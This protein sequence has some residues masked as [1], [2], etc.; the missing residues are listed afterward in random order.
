[1][2]E[3][4]EQSAESAEPQLERSTYEIIRNRLQSHA[5]ELRSRL[6]RLNDERREV[7]GSIETKLV[8]TARI[9]T[10]HNC[11]PR[12]MVPIGD[13][14][15]FGFNVLIGLRSEINLN[16]V[17][18][19]QK[20]EN[21][22]FHPEDLTLLNQD[23]LR[24]DFKE[25]YKYYKT[26]TFAKFHVIAPHVYM[27]FKVGKS[28]RDVKALK[29]LMD[30]DQ[31][32][33]LDNRNDHE[34][35]FPPKHGF[36]WT[37]TRRDLHRSGQHPHISV[38]DRVFVETIGG[39]LTVKV[40]DNTEAGTGIYSEPVDDPDQTLDDAEIFYA[41]V[42]N[43]ILLKIRPFKEE[44]FRYLVFN[45][46]TQSVTRLDTIENSCVLLPEDHGLIFSNGYYLQTGEWKIF[47]SDIRDLVF[48]K[49]IASP[50][51]EDYL[52]VFYN[53]DSGD[54]VI[55]PY[56]MIEQ[57]VLTP[58]V[59]NGYSLFDDGHLAFFKSEGNPQKHHAMQIWQTPFVGQDFEA[60]TQSD[61]YLFKLG[62]K[63][64]VRAMSECHE[65][66]GLI[67]KDD[68][69]ANLYVDL[70]KKTT[71]VL[72]SYFW[73]SNKETFDLGETLEEIKAAAVAAVDE[74]DKVV[75]VRKNTNTRFAES[76]GKVGKVLSSAASRMF[77]HIDEFVDSLAD[78]RVVRGEVIS[79]RELKY[80]DLAA[81]DRLEK[82]VEE[83]TSRIS[84]RCVDFLLREDSLAPYVARVQSQREA[85]EALEKVTTAKKLDEEISAG[86]TEL[87]MLIDIVSN[88]D[89]DD[90]TQRTRIID[91][92]S[93]IYSQL[94]QARASLKKKTT[95]LLSVEGIAEFNSQIK[96][97]SQAVVNYLDVCDTPERCD[98]Y[99]TKMMVQIEEL[100][101]RFAEFDEFIIQL[102]EKREEVYQAFDTRKIGLVE[103]RNKRAAALM[104]ACD[105]ILSGIK[106]RVSNF[107]SVNEINS[108]F[109]ADLMIEKVRDII[110]QLKELDDNVK[111]DDIQ[112]RL[113]STREDAVRQLKDKQELFVDGENVIKF[114]KHKFSVNIQTL[115]LT[116]VLKDGEL[117][118]HL[119]GTDFMEAVTD[120]SLL[121]TRD[122]WDQE[123]VS[124]NSSVYRGEYLAYQLLKSIEAKGPAAAKEVLGLESESLTDYVQKFMAPRYA[125]GYVKGVQD[126]DAALILHQLLDL[127]SS[128]G[129]LRYHV[130]ARSLATLFWLDLRHE[131]RKMQNA[132]LARIKAHGAIGKLFEASKGRSTHVAQLDSLIGEFSKKVDCFEN[133]L[134]TQAANFLYDL[135]SDSGKFF[136][137]SGTNELVKSFLGNLN[138]RNYEADF[139]KLVSE[140]KTSRIDQFLLVR[141]W[142]ASFIM[143]LGEESDREFV[144]EAAVMIMSPNEPQVLPG[145]ATRMLTGLLGNHPVA[146]VKEYSLDFN[147]FVLRLENYEK[148]VV[149]SYNQYIG[150][151]KRIV[152]DK[153]ELLRLE[154]FKPRVLTSFVRNKLI[155][156]V[157]L[158]MVGDNLAKQIGVI[159]DQKRTDLMGLLLLISPPGYG[160]TTLME[161]IANRLG[162]T[163]MKINGPAIGHQ[164]TSLDP[165]EAP[166]AS[167]RE[168]VIK[169]NLSLEMGDNVM[170]YL[171]DIQ[172]CNPEF[173]QKFIS[174]CDGS[175]RIE[176]VYKGKTRTYDLRGRKVAVVMAGNP[177]T[178]SG[179]KFQI[180]DMLSNRADT[181][182]LGDVIGDSAASFELS[183]LENCLTSNASL[184]VLHSRSRNDIYSIIHMAEQDEPQGEGLEGNYSV[185]EINELV[186]VMKKL[187]VIRDV[188]LKVNQQY[189]ASA[190]QA[191]EYRT[192]PAFKLQGSYR[193][194]NKLAEK[195]V[196]V[197]ND[198]EL[199][200]LIFSH[201]ENQ[202]QTLTTGA[203]ANL[204]KFKELIDDFSEEEEVRWNDI[205]RTF[206]RN[207]LLGSAGSGD[208][209][210]SLVIAQLTTFSEGLA[211]IKNTLDY[212]VA[213]IGGGK[214][215]KNEPTY[216][217]K[218]V[219]EQAGN[220]MQH[221]AEFNQTL[222]AIK[223]VLSNVSD[224]ENLNRIAGSLD[225]VKE[226]S[227]YQID[228]SKA[229]KLGKRPYKISV[230]NKI[231]TA[232]LDVISTQF[233]VLQS[234]VEPMA[235][236]QTLDADQFRRAVE[237]TFER[238][239][240][241]VKQV[242]DLSSSPPDNDAKVDPPL[243]KTKDSSE[244]SGDNSLPG[245]IFFPED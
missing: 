163:F 98:E 76:S 49:R 242:G 191:D 144:N 97:L 5:Q 209:K 155:D 60:T 230:V 196:P 107:D 12:D 175:R 126:H 99:L 6:G 140:I 166:N 152:A 137:A 231:P 16:D 189:I 23:S 3:D 233:T 75:R 225:V 127:K 13:R 199:D 142:V 213:A 47:E 143:Q 111:V 94:N 100:E 192:E 1:M 176:G 64:V 179:E 123:I 203:E 26:T 205:K 25:I 22:S 82:D 136:V 148:T 110:E 27:V 161:Y 103:S 109:A 112:S 171:D 131:N 202:A 15:I 195:V 8:E 39:D 70:V 20:F 239:K 194:M 135:L 18:A 245:G 227:S 30:G 201:F 240:E 37:R 174:L 28:A 133:A 160:K 7:F 19:V 234:W 77:R 66:I 198:K 157:Y 79:L 57:Q 52:Y 35:V 119:T 223:D 129:L 58:I 71:D 44:G 200:T 141:D 46:K 164:V 236:L 211:E 83:N 34:V 91:S 2:A 17:F 147:N 113:K 87:E 173:L 81:V 146:Q 214:K 210:F 68:S 38:D 40:E 220:A 32:T 117:F 122:V 125:E 114:G 187:L 78:L 124:E 184:G 14:F 121:A 153:R 208:D 178:E 145:N 139:E 72:D 224:L 158:P 67:E 159:G 92:I 162:I 106:T 156:E 116:T 43:I 216:L 188:L 53:Q 61:S 51:G 243:P 85:V 108:Y 56:N 36:Q 54:Y 219:T 182:N 172:H 50:N 65:I 149:P 29:F 95:E 217:E 45:E 33:Y 104:S 193:D 167:A 4:P 215:K 59:C 55:L 241:L 244:G 229:I 74:F 235:K 138:R 134:S 170:I 222:T 105:R 180:P 226:A 190:A 101:G 183:Y 115:D 181:Y 69:Y 132:I 206:K 89:I 185:E 218:V 177:Y 165:D 197:M 9:T 21:Q 168:E 24:H 102:S 11:V 120:E 204:L 62:N 42:G 118:F 88:L 84:K 90:A 150:L 169:L 207:L 41:I 80:V 93:T 86:S 237:A 130:D 232:F 10:D 186:A 48:E 151:K 221:L 63:D 31:L 96:L 212:G 128:I 154:E 228:E 238:Y 73:I